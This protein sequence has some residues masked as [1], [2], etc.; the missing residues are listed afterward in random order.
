[1]YKEPYGELAY[2]C[3][4]ILGCGGSTKKLMVS[5]VFL[6]KDT[7]ILNCSY[8]LVFQFQL[9]NYFSEEA[10]VIFKTVNGFN[11]RVTCNSVV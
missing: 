11:P 1:M 4:L 8:E 7:L 6:P 5:R 3:V 10:L 9:E 2:A